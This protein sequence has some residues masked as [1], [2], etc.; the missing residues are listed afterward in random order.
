MSD[1][2]DSQK[3]DTIYT[4]MTDKEVGLCVRVKSLEHTVN[5]NGEQ[6]LAEKVRFIEWKM[7]AVCAAVITIFQFAKEVFF[8]HGGILK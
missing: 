6:G 5:G 3:L 7:A 1:L 2:T 4:L 8:S